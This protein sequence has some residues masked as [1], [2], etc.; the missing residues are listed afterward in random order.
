MQEQTL[1]RDNLYRLEGPVAVIGVEL[2]EASWA[3]LFASHGRHVRLYDQYPQRL[4]SGLE[5][6][7]RYVHFLVNHDMATDPKRVEV[8]LRALGLALNSLKQ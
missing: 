3:A 2:T 5:R 4:A 8:G 1:R 6:A 7:C